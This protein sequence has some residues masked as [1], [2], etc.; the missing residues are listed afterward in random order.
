MRKNFFL[1]IYIGVTVLFILYV[2]IFYFSQ[3]SQNQIISNPN[4]LKYKLNTPISKSVLSNYQHLKTLGFSDPVIHN[5]N[6]DEIMRYKKIKGKLAD[7]ITLYRKMK[8]YNVKHISKKEY[9]KLLKQYSNAKLPKKTSLERVYLRMMNEGDNHIFLLTEH[10]F[11]YIPADVK[12]MT[13]EVQY[14]ND[15][16]VKNQFAKQIWW[17]S[18]TFYSK[19]IQHGVVSYPNPATSLPESGNNFLDISP[20]SGSAFY[21][22]NWKQSS[23]F[24]EVIGLVFYQVSEFEVPKNYIR[25]DVYIQGQNPYLSEQLTAKLTNKK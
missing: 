5:M 9:Q 11:D 20:P 24:H 18:S 1:S 15:Y 12:P 19:N 21:P 13:V 7:K 16:I 10:H 22:I 6:N 2:G 4:T 3:T 23:I 14:R 25:A 8:G 17:T